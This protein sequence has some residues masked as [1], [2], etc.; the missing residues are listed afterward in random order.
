VAVSGQGIDA[1]ENIAGRKRHIGV[2][3]LGVLLAVLVTAASVSDNT[4]IHVL[5]IIVPSTPASPTHGLRPAAAG[6]TGLPSISTS[7]VL[8]VS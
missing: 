3:T 7:D 5:S 2:D 8:I 6:F 4:D 1:G